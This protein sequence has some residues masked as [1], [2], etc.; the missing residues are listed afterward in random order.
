MTKG[1][2]GIARCLA[3]AL[4]MFS[5][6]GLPDVARAG[7]EAPLPVVLEDVATGSATELAPGAAALH[8][9]FFAPWCP[10]CLDELKALTEMEERWSDRGYRL[11]LIAV[12]NRNTRERLLRFSEQQRAPGKIYLDA[13]GEAQR[14]FAAEEI[15]TH[16]LLDAT[17][18]V[19]GRWPGLADEV[20]QGVR[21]LLLASSDGS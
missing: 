17:G 3:P 8:V 16:F 6:S 13:S 20:E 21:K 14:S 7:S 10:S 4:L 12:R 2:V 11:I 5:L 15:P 1:L 19:V 9:V 18:R